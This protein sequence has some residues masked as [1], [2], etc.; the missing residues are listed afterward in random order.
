M[1]EKTREQLSRSENEPLRGR[2][3]AETYR[4]SKRRNRYAFIKKGGLSGKILVGIAFICLL[5]LLVSYGAEVELEGRMIDEGLEIIDPAYLPWNE[6]TAPTQKAYLWYT[7]FYH[8]GQMALPIIVFLLVRQSL[9]HNLY[10]EM[11]AFGLAGLGSEYLF[12]MIFYHMPGTFWGEQNV[13]ITLTTLLVFL[14]SMRLLRPWRKKTKRIVQVLA[15]ALTTALFF[16]LL[17]LG[18]VTG[19]SDTTYIFVLALALLAMPNH[20]LMQAASMGILGLS[21]IS[22]SV[23]AALLFFYNDQEPGPKALATLPA[24]YILGLLG[25]Y[26]LLP[27]LI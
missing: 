2:A 15:T 5:C 18:N 25:L 16:F 3:N 11:L 12:D 27:S 26:Y 23:P 7:V 6:V 19:L 14:Q 17:L 24:L 4:E 10:W 22:R 13:F 20:V 21:R 9:T 1:K 8:L